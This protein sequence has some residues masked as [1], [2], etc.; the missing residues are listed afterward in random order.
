MLMLMEAPPVAVHMYHE[1]VCAPHVAMKLSCFAHLKSGA[2]STRVGFLVGRRQPIDCTARRV[3]DPKS[4]PS[5][6]SVQ[7]RGREI[8]GP[9][10]LK[11]KAMQQIR[12][13]AS[14]D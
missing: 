1:V 8:R 4:G 9:G 7:R 12:S 2:V 14:R 3:E 13:H 11:D 5:P 10:L 6:R